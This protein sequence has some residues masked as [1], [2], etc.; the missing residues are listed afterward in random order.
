MHV[1]SCFFFANYTFLD[2]VTS[3]LGCLESWTLET[4][5]KEVFFFFFFSIFFLY[6]LNFKIY[7]YYLINFIFF[8]STFP[9]ALY[10]PFFLVIIF[11]YKYLWRHFYFQN[12]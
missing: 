3:V 5:G 6:F 10:S 9:Y 2:F 11:F 8:H 4:T 12:V 1:T 7:N